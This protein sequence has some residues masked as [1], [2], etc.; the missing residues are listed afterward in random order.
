MLTPHMPSNMPGAYSGLS[1]LIQAAT[2]Q[3]GDFTEIDNSETS[4]LLESPPML[5]NPTTPTFEGRQLLELNV[6]SSSS[7]RR[8]EST[9][10]TVTPLVSCVRHQEPEGTSKCCFPEVLMLLLSNPI[11]ADV[12]TFLPDGKY[13]AIR[14]EE[15]TNQLLSKHF[16]L[17]CFGD[18]LEVAKDWG[19]I[20]VNGKIN[21][22]DDNAGDRNSSMNNNGN[23]SD[24]NEC[25]NITAKINSSKAEIYVF[26]RFHFEQNQPV[27]T[28][29]VRFKNGDVQNCQQLHGSS[30]DDKDTP[31]LSKKIS[32]NGKK[33]KEKRKL[34]SSPTNGE[35]Q[36]SA[37]RLRANSKTNSDG[38]N[39]I[40]L[41]AGSCD[42][43]IH[44]L[45]RRSSLELWGMAQ[46]ITSSK[47]CTSNG[48]ER[49]KIDVIS[50]MRHS[51]VIKKSNT[52]SSPKAPDPIMP[53][54]LERQSTGSSLVDGGVETA[55]HTIVT[56][57]I[58]AL[59]F[60]ENHTRE[61]YNRHEKELSTS[62]LPGVVPI[63]KQLF[64][65][66]DNNG[67]SSGT[68]N[69]DNN[70]KCK[71]MKKIPKSRGK[72]ATTKPKPDSSSS[73]PMYSSIESLEDASKKNANVDPSSPSFLNCGSLRVVI[74]KDGCEYRQQH[75]SIYGSMVVSP[76]RMEAAAA[77][78]SQSRIKNS[79]DV[80]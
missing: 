58:E 16:G 11:Y 13:F 69:M 72:V 17:T 77:L 43:P 51:S 60:D 44:Q 55:T 45:R 9:I 36:N 26:R 41:S 40:P 30:I 6:T 52:S 27:D 23:N 63:S 1:A 34:S 21:E 10:A 50:N 53:P 4:A 68:L 61:T 35:S 71:T 76:A 19:F 37:Q 80:I 28:N 24:A 66:S 56:D 20:R 62:S 70:E 65:A 67:V 39:P 64:S 38:I 59:L 22:G 57:A 14:R 5:S 25:T 48:S 31:K 79:E 32:R 7:W 3:L 42:R 49:I 46:A 54:Q 18:F 74:P 47:I 75:K 8:G 2:S 15:F 12:V 73:W 78:V 29:K 33:S